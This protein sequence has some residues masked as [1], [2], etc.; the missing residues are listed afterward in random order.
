M[1][2]FV[3]NVNKNVQ[4]RKSISALTKLNTIK[5]RASPWDNI[6]IW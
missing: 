1:I 2:F 6:I 5:R 3:L 4:R